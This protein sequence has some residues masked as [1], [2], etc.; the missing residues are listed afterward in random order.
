LVKETH[1][2]RKA[3]PDALHEET[4]RRS[5]MS[6]TPPRLLR[7]ACQV[8]GGAAAFSERL[9]ISETMLERF[10]SGTFPVPDRVLLAAVDVMLQE[11]EARLTAPPPAASAPDRDD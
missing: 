2:S 6:S 4:G 10:M 1:T 8:A 7:A 9:G 5:A 3:V 11:R